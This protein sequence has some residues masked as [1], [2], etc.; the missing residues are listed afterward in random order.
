[1]SVEYLERPRGIT[2]EFAW[3]LAA[4]ANIRGYMGDRE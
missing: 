4:E 2:Y 1:M 3:E